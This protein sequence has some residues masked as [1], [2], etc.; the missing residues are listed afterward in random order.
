VTAQTYPIVVTS[1]DGGENWELFSVQTI[2]WTSTGVSGP[3]KIE[4][5]RDGGATWTTIIPL[6]PN[7]GSQ[8]WRILRGA[9]TQARIKVSSIANPTMF[10][11]SNANF[12]IVEPSITVTS[13]GGGES[14]KI[15]STQTITWDSTSVLLVKIELSR[16]SGATWTTIAASIANHGSKSWKVTGPATTNARIRVVSLSNSASDISNADFTITP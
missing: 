11:I 8:R 15:G 5:S 2:T 13:P 9:T 6:T 7:D 12:T 1:P 10:D 14:W 16:D 3:V 4:L